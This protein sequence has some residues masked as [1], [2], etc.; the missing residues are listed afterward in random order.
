VSDEAVRLYIQASDLISAEELTS[1]SLEFVKTSGNGQVVLSRCIDHWNKS[2]KQPTDRRIILLL[3]MFRSP[4]KTAKSS[5]QECM[6][7][8]G[9][10]VIIESIDHATLDRSALYDFSSSGFVVEVTEALCSQFSRQL[11]EVVRWFTSRND[12]FQASQFTKTRLSRWTNNEICAIALILREPSE[13]ISKELHK[14]KV[15]RWC[16]LVV[17]G[18]AALSNQSKV[19]FVDKLLSHKLL[20]TATDQSLAELTL[21][22]FNHGPNEFGI[23]SVV[24]EL[25]RFPWNER[26]LIQLVQGMK[27][28]SQILKAAERTT[29]VDYPV[30]YTSFYRQVANHGF[31]EAIVTASQN[32]QP[33]LVR[34]FAHYV[35]SIKQYVPV[36]FAVDFTGLAL[37]ADLPEL[38]VELSRKAVSNTTSALTNWSAVMEHWQNDQKHNDWLS[39]QYPK[40]DALLWE[41][42]LFPVNEISESYL[43]RYGPATTHYLRMNRGQPHN[44]EL[45]KRLAEHCAQL[46]LV[47][48]ARQKAVDRIIA[49]TK[50][51]HYAGGGKNSYKNS[52]YAAGGYM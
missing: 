10:S 26:N 22:L 52:N 35:I 4:T 45:L 21:K 11:V 39:I 32:D 43:V 47:V 27:G 50:N 33:W 24:K 23:V 16:I 15:I 19:A 3:E 17:M 7:L 42:L 8:F 44:S 51:N 9:R 20:L 13:W 37:K 31:V 41:R 48:A 28:V 2:S 38:A 18:S 6:L 29:Y 14:R 46:R 30:P 40:H 25:Q 36:S 34:A 1:E 49:N 5:A 12:F